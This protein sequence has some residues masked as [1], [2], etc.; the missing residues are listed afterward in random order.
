T[1]PASSSKGPASSTPSSSTQVY[2]KKVKEVKK[3][4]VEEDPLL[5]H[6]ELPSGPENI[7]VLSESEDNE[8]PNPADTFETTMDKEQ[9]I[10]STKP[11]RN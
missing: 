11:P 6:S 9:E 8:M 7:I 2:Q 10:H 3:D 1:P 4:P 5:K